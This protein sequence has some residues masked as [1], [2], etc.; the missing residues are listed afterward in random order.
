MLVRSFAL[1]LYKMNLTYLGQCFVFFQ[2]KSG[3]SVGML[4]SAP[5]PINA[6]EPCISAFS[7]ENLKPFCL[8]LT[9]IKGLNHLII[10]I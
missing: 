10:M 7:I 4:F 3:F 8:F 6:L 2:L 1:Y 5:N 9:T